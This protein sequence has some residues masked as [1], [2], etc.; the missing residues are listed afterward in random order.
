MYWIPLLVFVPHMLEE[1]PRFPAWAT[2]HFGATSRAWYVY[3]HV[4]LVALIVGVAWSTETSRPGSWGALMAVGVMW[5]LACNGGFHL[6]TTILFRQYSPGVV[7]GTVLFFP[8]TAYLLWQVIA[9]GMLSA[10]Q[11]ALSILIGTAVQVG[12]IASL[13]LEMDIDWTGHRRGRAHGPTRRRARSLE[14]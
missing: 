3:S 9:G 8:A 11:V 1:F 12:V 6:V 14:P 13:W 5:S 10:S 4:V 2:R 7:T